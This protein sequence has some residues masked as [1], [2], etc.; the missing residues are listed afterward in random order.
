MRMNNRTV[1]VT[2]ASGATGKAIVKKYAE[3]GANVVLASRNL[4]KLEEVIDELSLD[5]KKAV[6]V[7]VDI[8]N[9][10]AISG[11]L[12]EVETTFGKIDVL[13]CNSGIAGD[14]NSTADYAVDQFDNVIRTNLRGTFLCIKLTIPR[15]IKNGG[16][17][18]VPISSV[19]GLKGMPDTVG[20]NA[21]KFAINGMVRSVC[22]E[23][24]AKGIR[25]NA[26]CPSPIAGGMMLNT[27]KAYAEKAGVDVET[28]HNQITSTIPM[29]RYA[30][31]EE[32]A[33]AA[34]FLGSDE[35]SFIN[36]VTLPVDGGIS[37]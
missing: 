5:R 11:M 20:Y 13:V 26:V 24:A 10:D 9:E 25:I 32:V 28:I 3:E 12:D 2:G 23:Y 6:A 22:V 34:F 21:S 29:G 17:A 8:D 31:P 4:K 16:G 35:A 36:G 7:A 19:G 33:D 30:E 37:A 15:M 14:V 27:E 1:I 18:I